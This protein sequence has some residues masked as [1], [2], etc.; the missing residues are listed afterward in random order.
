[1]GLNARKETLEKITNDWMELRNQYGNN[2]N[3]KKLIEDMLKAVYGEYN[4]DIIFTD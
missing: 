4:I 2:P 1:M 3:I